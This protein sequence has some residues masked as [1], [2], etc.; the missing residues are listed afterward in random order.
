MSK[1]NAFFIAIAVSIAASL[2]GCGGSSP[3]SNSGGTGGG[4]APSVV[5]NG[6]YSGSYTVQGVGSS[7]IV[8]AIGQA[9]IGYFADSLGF[10]Y[11]LPA[12]PSS[13]TISGSLTGYA[14]PGQTFQSG[15]R[16]QQFAVT[17]S[18][19][20]ATASTISGTF[21]GGGESGTFSLSSLSIS[22]ATQASLTGQYSGAYWG[23]SGSRVNVTIS[24]SGAISGSDGLGC[25][26]S[27]SA[28]PATGNVLT[29]TVS[30]TGSGCAGSLSGIGFASTSDLS[31][32]FSGAAG[33]YL[34]FGGS[35]TASAFA[36]ELKQQ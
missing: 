34:Y 25:L 7:N 28:T 20:G 9:G 30:A 23:S 10:V 6:A 4:A 29:I 21:N 2:A 27:G 1:P 18:A 17:G 3:V 35:N 22:S 32:I 24:S 8:G 33:S 11:V 31:G 19:S 13:G 14:P 15:Q 26:L 12:I 16:V 36:A 5:A